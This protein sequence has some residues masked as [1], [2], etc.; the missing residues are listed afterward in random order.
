MW[1]LTGVGVVCLIVLR[2]WIVSKIW[3]WDRP[4]IAANEQFHR[5]FNAGEYD[6]ICQD[7]DAAIQGPAK[8]DALTKLL[9]AVHA[10]LGN[11]TAELPRRTTFETTNLGKFVVVIYATSFEKGSAIEEITWKRE[12]DSLRLWAYKIDSSAIHASWGLSMWPKPAS[13]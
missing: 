13:P 11:A 8:D 10:T 7:T 3:Q 6:Q 1:L 5:E 9:T 12:R 4:V 2:Y